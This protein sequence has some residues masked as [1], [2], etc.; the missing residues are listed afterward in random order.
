RPPPCEAL[1]ESIA[2]DEL[3]AEERNHAVGCSAQ[4][5]FPI[6]LAKALQGDKPNLY[7]ALWLSLSGQKSCFCPVWRRDA[8]RFSRKGSAPANS[9]AVSDL[10]CKRSSTLDQPIETKRLREGE[11]VDPFQ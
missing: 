6:L 10:L 8:S 11:S 7:S 9:P 3:R 1:A 2:E 5:G 4:K